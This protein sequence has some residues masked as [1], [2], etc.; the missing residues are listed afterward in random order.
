MKAQSLLD[1]AQ[2]LGISLRI[3]GDHIRYRPKSVAPSEFVEELRNQKAEIIELLQDPHRQPQFGERRR[4][5]ACL[6]DDANGGGDTCGACNGRTCRD[7]GNCLRASQLWREAE[8]YAKYLDR[9]LDTILDRLRKGS[10]WLRGKARREADDTE[11]YLEIFNTWAELEEV[12]RAIHGYVDCIFGA[13]HRCPEDAP[14]T[15]SVCVSK[16]GNRGK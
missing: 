8:R 4:C 16:D 13:G 2:H 6:C 15:C 3:V 1:R 7:C 12:L 10:I 5:R 9:S 14:V 11:L